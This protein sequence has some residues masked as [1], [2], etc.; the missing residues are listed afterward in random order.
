MQSLIILIIEVKLLEHYFNVID[1]YSKMYC[2]LSE[3]EMRHHKF[4]SL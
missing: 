3:S 1:I 2:D 4:F